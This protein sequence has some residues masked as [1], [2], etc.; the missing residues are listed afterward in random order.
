M[1]LYWVAWITGFFGS[2]HCVGMCGP[3]ALSIQGNAKFLSGLLQNISYNV[4]R[5][6]AYGLL[7]FLFGYFGQTLSSLA[8]WQQYLSI[9]SGVVILLISLPRLLKKTPLWLRDLNRRLSS[10]ISALIGKG[11]MRGWGHWVV[12]FLNGFL[13]C[14]FVYMALAGSVATGDTGQATLFMLCFGLGTFPLMFLMGISPNL[15]SPKLRN[16]LFRYSAYFAVLVAFIFILRGMNLGIPYL[17][18]SIDDPNFCH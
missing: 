17:S 16:H 4:G 13:P 7:G 15:L 9:I 2:L 12:G 10:P 18:P 6:S 5:F 14:G 8:G 3:L 11:I 1:S